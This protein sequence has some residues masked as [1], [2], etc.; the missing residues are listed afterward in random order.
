MTTS[1][2]FPH[3]RA[4]GVL[5][6]VAGLFLFGISTAAAQAATCG[7]PI[8]PGPYG[9]TFQSGGVERE[10]VYVIPS[11]YTG[12]KK[13]P[14]VLDFHGSNSNPKVQLGRSHWNEVAEREGFVVMALAGSLK[15]E[16]PNTH[17][18]NVPGVTAGQ[19]ADDSRRPRGGPVPWHRRSVRCP[20]CP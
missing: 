9:L 19:G 8:E 11:S 6:V 16:L 10:A 4:R 17:A 5:R 7:S 1:T 20:C 3:V 14:L 15:G 18:W 2:V 13:V 12:K